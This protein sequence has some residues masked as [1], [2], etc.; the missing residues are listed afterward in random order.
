MEQRT[1]DT[2]RESDPSSPRDSPQTDPD[3]VLEPDAGPLLPEPDGSGA[4]DSP[5]FELASKPKKRLMNPVID[6]F[7]SEAQRSKPD[8]AST[9]GRLLLLTFSL[10]H[11]LPFIKEQS[12][13]IRVNRIFNSS[14]QISITRSK[15][16][17][18]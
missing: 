6:M 2:G 7:E 15:V 10:L 17:L 5:V 4:R 8:N 16:H 14:F 11:L 3:D 13:F 9:E 12:M 18:R 1:L